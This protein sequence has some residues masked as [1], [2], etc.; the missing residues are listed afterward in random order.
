MG[1]G[2]NNDSWA[3]QRGVTEWLTWV[4]ACMVDLA[5]ISCMDCVGQGCEGSTLALFGEKLLE[6]VLV[7]PKIEEMRVRSQKAACD[8]HLLEAT[9]CQAFALHQSRSVEQES[10]L[11]Q[12]TCKSCP[13]F[14]DALLWKGPMSL[15]VFGRFKILEDMVHVRKKLVYSQGSRVLVAYLYRHLAT[16]HDLRDSESSS[17]AIASV[18]GWRPSLVGGW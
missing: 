2:E 14:R 8:H 18:V 5:Q 1:W 15:W 10:W 7:R 3:G 12:T 16:W 4:D 6:K 9:C 11:P 17:A 13:Y